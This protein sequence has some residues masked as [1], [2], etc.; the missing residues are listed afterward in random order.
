M[1]CFVFSFSFSFYFL[2]VVFVIT[3]FDPG[4]TFEFRPVP[5]LGAADTGCPSVAARSVSF[6]CAF[7]P[8][9]FSHVRLFALLL[10]FKSSLSTF[11]LH[12]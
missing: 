9:D 1:P 7:F 5:E 12:S 4:A 2:F 8:G 3:A 6:G 11:Q 10:V